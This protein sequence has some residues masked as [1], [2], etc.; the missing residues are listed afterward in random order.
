MPFTFFT[1][2][3]PL[4]SPV[5]PTPT[6]GQPLLFSTPNFLPCGSPSRALHAQ[7]SAAPV[8]SGRGEAASQAT[9]G[10][11]ETGGRQRLAC[12]ETVTGRSWV[13]AAQP[14]GTGYATQTSGRRMAELGTQSGA[15]PCLGEAPSGATVAQTDLVWSCGFP[16][17][18]GWLEGAGSQHPG[19]SNLLRQG[20]S[21]GCRLLRTQEACLRPE[22]LP[23]GCGSSR[24]FGSAA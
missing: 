7:G 22:S 13:V 12:V 15:T 19:G 17:W 21:V 2:H 6:L 10:V 23:A 8:F 24:D 16:G 4:A 5:S 11:M 14:V 20:C 18:R 9:P 1:S 3:P